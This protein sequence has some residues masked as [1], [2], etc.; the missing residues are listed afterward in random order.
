MELVLWARGNVKYRAVF[1]NEEI[2]V[3]K[4]IYQE[5]LWEPIDVKTLDKDTILKICNILLKDEDLR[6]EIFEEVKK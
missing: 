4:E 6:K 5:G 1:K 2:I 3:Y